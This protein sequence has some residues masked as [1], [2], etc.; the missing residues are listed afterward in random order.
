M[1]TTA[2]NI[3]TLI[4]QKFPILAQSSNKLWIAASDLNLANNAT[5]S[6]INNKANTNN[7]LTL[8]S[9]K[10]EGTF[11]NNAINGRPAI[12]LANNRSYSFTRISDIRTVF[13]VL[14]ESSK[15]NSTQKIILKLEKLKFA[16]LFSLLST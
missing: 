6:T 10:T 13:W 11:N 1:S 14:K 4:S 16:S 3:S 2:E 8:Q 5:V 15:L 12:T 7:N 9:G